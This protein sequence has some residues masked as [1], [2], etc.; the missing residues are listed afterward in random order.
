MNVGREGMRV[1]NPARWLLSLLPLLAVAVQGA[2]PELQANTRLTDPQFIAEGAK[3][4]ATS[5][6][7][8]YCHG[9]GAN[10][11]GAPRLRGKGLDADYTF[12]TISNGVPNTSMPGFKTELSEERI[13]KLVAF[14]LSDSKIDAKESA[15]SSA[16]EARS[17]KSGKAAI[18]P[19]AGNADAGKM[20]F[21]DSSKPK[22]CHA[23]HSFKGEGTQIGPDL[24]TAAETRSARALFSSIVLVTEIKD[25]KYA[26]ITVSLR[27]GEKIVGV[28]KD[29]DAESL[30]VYDT[31]ELPAVLRTIQKENVAGIEQSNESVMPRDYASLYTMKQLLD[32]VTF[33]K[34]ANSRSPVTLKELVE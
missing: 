12:K 7:N 5:C 31:S 21:F 19:L 27:N 2:R 24:S 14:I 4:F 26:S 11:G 28:K 33:L 10:G 1:S 29:E 8:A 23:C 32:L 22:S 6:G 9:T 17:V 13:W 15:S 20:L 25:S 18:Q 3:L 34:S 16:S 30:R